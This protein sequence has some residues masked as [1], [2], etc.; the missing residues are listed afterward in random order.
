MSDSKLLLNHID[1]ILIQ[2]RSKKLLLKSL[3]LGLYL[4]SLPAQT[5]F[6][7][8]GAII[9]QKSISDYSFEELIIIEDSL[10]A[11]NLT[12]ELNGV[13]DYH[14]RKAKSENDSVEL[15]SIYNWRIWRE[16]FET[17]K[18][19]SDS[20]INISKTLKNDNLRAQSYYSFGTY[21]YLNNRPIEGL[22]MYIRAYQLSDSIGLIDNSIESL[23]GIA[24]I[25]REYGLA[26]QALET[27]MFSLKKLE[28]NKHLL[29]DYFEILGYTL[30]AASKCFLETN[31]QDLA[32]K[33]AKRGLKVAA[34]LD[35]QALTN[36]FET[37]IGQSLFG[38][39]KLVE[40]E[41]KLDSL[42]DYLSDESLA[43]I[44]YYLGKISLNNGNTDLTIKHF[45][46]FDSIVNSLGYP[47]IDHAKEV[48]LFLLNNA[49]VNGNA[50]ERQVYLNNLVFYDSV[51]ELTNTEVEKIS[52]IYFKL[53][54]DESLDHKESRSYFS[55][56]MVLGIAS[57]CLILF[58]ITKRSN[59]RLLSKS[60]NKVPNKIV[61]DVLKQL[62]KWEENHGYLES[63]V[64]QVELASI[65][66]TNSSYLSK[67]INENLG[68]SYSAYIKDLRT[69]YIINDFDR[70]YL[71]LMKKSMIQLAENYGFKSQDS[72]VRAFKEKTGKTPSSYLKDRKNEN[73]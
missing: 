56:I 38:K 30:D 40:S 3:S 45:S 16:K 58:S 32:I 5:I 4:S 7:Q 59:S 41:K 18:R 39:G 31:Q 69:N 24:A 44:Y 19:Y 61:L 11:K 73:N 52:S 12:T 49:R 57:I 28:K 29:E 22:N 15:V 23:N 8:E 72:F 68:V 64:T 46:S 33:H 66:G 71:I 37:I 50:E 6:A 65:L 36:S 53:Q 10:E 14:I 26:F 70:N 13:L 62:R 54:G 20:A 48:Y 35:D 55:L 9:D 51:I 21:S 17:A 2:Q 25:K 67:V 60:I 27:Q 43:D 42:I 47:R 1:S 63:N 34:V